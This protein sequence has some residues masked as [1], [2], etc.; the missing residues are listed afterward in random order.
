MVTNGVLLDKDVRDARR[1]LKG[2]RGS[3]KEPEAAHWLALT[4]ARR[5]AYRSIVHARF[6]LDVTVQTT[7]SVA[8]HFARASRPARRSKLRHQIA[9]ARRVKIDASDLP[10]RL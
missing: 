7:L 9:A 8:I 3:A 5:D 4:L 6:D 10:S 1:R 2:L